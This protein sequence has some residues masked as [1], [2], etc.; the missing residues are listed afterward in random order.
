LRTTD[1]FY[2]ARGA[3]PIDTYTGGGYGWEGTGWDGGGWGGYVGAGEWGGGWSG[4]G[5]YVD[6]G[7]WSGGYADWG[8]AWDTGGGGTG[9]G[10]IYGDL[11]GGLD[12]GG[13]S[14]SYATGGIAATPQIASIAEGGPE[15]V[16]PYEWA[17]NFADL[18]GLVASKS[19]DVL[20]QPEAFN[21]R[22]TELAQPAMIPVDDTLIRAIRSDQSYGN[23]DIIL[24]VDG[25]ELG[26]IAGKYITAEIQGRQGV[27]LA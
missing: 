2:T 26:R 27:K 3:Q 9:G 15:V 12:L 18:A 8:S 24:V 4:Y 17:S 7:G 14:W 22:Q 25:R 5:G 16:L 10:G 13:W 6:T 19:M 20:Y 23:R 1:P 21:V 11:G